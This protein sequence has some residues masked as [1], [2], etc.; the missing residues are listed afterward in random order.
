MEL[1]LHAKSMLVDQLQD[2]IR[3]IES[4][5]RDLDQNSQQYKQTIEQL[6]NE[7]RQIS[8][9]SHPVP[10]H[11]EEESDQQKENYEN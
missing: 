6:Q 8:E 3:I 10:R 5:N 1:E 7:L 11:L 9:D 4:Q 2:Q